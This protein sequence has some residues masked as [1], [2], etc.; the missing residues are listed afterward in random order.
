MQKVGINKEIQLLII[1]LLNVYVDVIYVKYINFIIQME[2][3]NIQ[4]GINF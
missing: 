2:Q 3:V 1:E 4:K